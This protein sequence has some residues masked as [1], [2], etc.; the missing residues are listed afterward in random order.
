MLTTLLLL[1]GPLRSRP[2]N[3]LIRNPLPLLPLRPLPGLI[4]PTFRRLSVD[5]GLPCSPLPR[6]VILAH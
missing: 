6:R 2:P 3:R 1:P 4:C 5:P